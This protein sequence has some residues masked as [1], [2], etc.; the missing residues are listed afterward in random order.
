MYPAGAHRASV[1]KL[2][3][4]Y[5][6]GA[7][8]GWARQPGLRSVQEELERAIERILGEPLAL[9]VAGRT[10]RGVHAWGQVASYRHEALDPRRPERA[11][12]R[13]TSRCSPASRPA[14]TSTRAAARAAGPT[15]TASC[16]G[17]CARRS[18]AGRALWVPWPI[19]R[20]ALHA[21]AAALVGTHSFTAFTPTETDHVRFERDVLAARWEE[22][23]E[24]LEFWIEADSFMR[25]MNRA[26]VGTMLE[27]ARGRRS[28]DEFAAL[29]EGRP[30]SE[31]G[32]DA[33]AARPLP[34]RGLLRLT[35]NR[36]AGGCGPTGASAVAGR[37]VAA[38]RRNI[39]AGCATSC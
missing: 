8:A 17:R 13:R 18:S 39:L 20:A 1:T 6:G 4:A 31:G 23:G 26:L 22:R 11:A 36:C 15:A 10:D 5:D 30:R 38:A 28:V 25:Q 33:A 37:C 2:T 9:S 27:V 35:A 24:L 32:A 3:L 29:L 7:F 21:C 34:R 12:A 14:R 16:A 19:D